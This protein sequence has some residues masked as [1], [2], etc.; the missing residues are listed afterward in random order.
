MAWRVATKPLSPS[1]CSVDYGPRQMPRNMKLIDY[2]FGA[3]KFPSHVLVGF[4]YTNIVSCEAV[5]TYQA[6]REQFS[7]ELSAVNNG[8]RPCPTHGS[9]I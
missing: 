2:K 1:A 3:L 4:I 8:E 5:H 9:S 6:Y 7:P